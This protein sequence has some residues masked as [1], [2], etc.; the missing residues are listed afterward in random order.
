MAEAVDG[1]TGCFLFPPFW[2]VS[3]SSGESWNLSPSPLK[4]EPVTFL[5][6]GYPRRQWRLYLVFHLFVCCSLFEDVSGRAEAPGLCLEAWLVGYFPVWWMSGGLC[7][8]AACPLTRE[9]MISFPLRQTNFTCPSCV[10]PFC[11]WGGVNQCFWVKLKPY[12]ATLHTQLT[13]A[14]SSE[15]SLARVI[16]LLSITSWHFLHSFYL[17]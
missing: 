8:H 16:F 12:L 2:S 5:E 9:Q 15:A 4:M 3:T 1:E 7:P 14:L 11:C 13:S 10:K 6:S 17:S